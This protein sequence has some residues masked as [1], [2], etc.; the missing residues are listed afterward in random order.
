MHRFCAGVASPNVHIF[1]DAV[2]LKPSQVMLSIQGALNS[3]GGQVRLWVSQKRA[4]VLLPTWHWGGFRSHQYRPPALQPLQHLIW[5]LWKVW[6]LS[7]SFSCSQHVAIK[8]RGPLIKWQA[9]KTKNL[10]FSWRYLWVASILVNCMVLY[11]HEQT[12]L[13]AKSSMVTS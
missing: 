7:C 12:N 1:I 3:C 11:F 10:G 5:H 9:L 2:F 6:H 8:W 13:D 4:E